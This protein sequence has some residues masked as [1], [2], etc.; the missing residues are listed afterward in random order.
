[1]LRTCLVQLTVECRH[2]LRRRPAE[3]DECQEEAGLPD[4]FEPVAKCVPQRRMATPQQR[5][6]LIGASQSCVTTSAVSGNDASYIDLFDYFFL[7]NRKRSFPFITN[8][9]RSQNG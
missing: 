6:R 5:L 7:Y 3:G 2:I 4:R 1:M 8:I 9:C